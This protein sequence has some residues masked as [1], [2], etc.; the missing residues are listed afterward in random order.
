MLAYN[1]FTTINNH[2]RPLSARFGATCFNKF[3]EH[4][5][6]LTARMNH[7]QP[8][9]NPNN[10]HLPTICAYQPQSVDNHHQQPSIDNQPSS[11]TILTTLNP[12]PLTIPL[13]QG[14]FLV[15]CGT[16]GAWLHSL[17]P[18]R[19][20]SWQGKTPGDLINHKP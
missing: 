5:A 2:H 12:W 10:H 18:K 13:C 8:V 6:L 19:R 20:Q 17:G 3:S 14:L 7:P 11:P 4:Q 15:V 1:E 9:N 16:A